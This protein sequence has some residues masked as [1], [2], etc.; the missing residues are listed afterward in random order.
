MLVSDILSEYLRYLRQ[1]LVLI[2]V[3][4]DVGL[5]LYSAPVTENEYGS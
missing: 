4:V 1:K 2:L 5:G 3:L